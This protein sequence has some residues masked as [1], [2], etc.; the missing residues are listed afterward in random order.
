MG[1]TYF[2]KDPA[3]KAVDAILAELSPE[4]RARVVAKATTFNAVFLVV[5]RDA[6]EN[7]TVYVPVNGKVREIAVFAT[8][9]ARGY[10]N[11]GYKDMDETMGPYGVPAPAGILKAASPLAPMTA[12]EAAK[13]FS[14]LKSA[15]EYRAAS[16]A[17][18]AL[19]T[20]RAK[21]NPGAKVTLATP[22]TFSNGATHSEFTV[23]RLKSKG[24]LKTL[25]A[26]P[27]G[28]YY[29]VSAAYLN[30]AVVA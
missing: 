5:E 15:A 17:Y 12:A 26:G 9:K 30:G 29:R 7:E 8:A 1:W 13:D 20:K 10:Q 23:V 2:H 24:K 19:K 18:N 28:V 27:D 11:F 21:L 4:T 25:F 16:A 3:T 14:S 22:L 6:F